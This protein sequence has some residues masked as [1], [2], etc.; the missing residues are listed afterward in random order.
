MKGQGSADMAQ[1][2]PVKLGVNDPLVAV[3]SFAPDP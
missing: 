2:M 1:G 3:N